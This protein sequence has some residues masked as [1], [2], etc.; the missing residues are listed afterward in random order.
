[1]IKDKQRMTDSGF[2]TPC[3]LESGYQCVGGIFHL[4]LKSSHFNPE[5]GAGMFRRYLVQDYAVTMQKTTIWRITAIKS[6]KLS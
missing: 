3:N 6:S 4:H 5:D 2:L 1:V